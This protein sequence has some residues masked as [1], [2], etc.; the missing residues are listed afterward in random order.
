M[1]NMS[2]LT[3]EEFL[4]FKTGLIARTDSQKNI[5]YGK[6]NGESVQRRLTE[7]YQDLKNLARSKRSIHG[8]QNQNRRL[9]VNRLRF[10]LNNSTYLGDN[11]PTGVGFD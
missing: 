11:K 2:D 4:K 6:N 3:K 9:F 1:N 7:R 10:G 8:R 5:R